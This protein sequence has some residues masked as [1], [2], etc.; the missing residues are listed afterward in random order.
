M[1]GRITF[2]LMSEG[3]LG[4]GFTG[5]L[6]VTL[7]RDGQ[8]ITLGQNFSILQSLKQ[9]FERAGDILLGKPFGSTHNQDGSLSTQYEAI[10]LST[11]TQAVSKTLVISDAV[12]DKLLAFFKET[13]GRANDYGLLLGQNCLD[14]ADAVFDMTGAAG[15]ISDL[16]TAQELSGS[17]VGWLLLSR[18]NKELP[19]RK[20]DA[21]TFI[22]TLAPREQKPPKPISSSFAGADIM[23]PM[24]L[25][26]VM[27]TKMVRRKA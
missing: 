15:D 9:S 10:R 18:K 21:K 22:S 17:T 4:S 16:F 20:M 3:L 5:H 8:S 25:L 13:D 12:Y 7:T 2:N 14:F 6:N 27:L 24:L 11:S 23:I 26:I 1:P 19:L